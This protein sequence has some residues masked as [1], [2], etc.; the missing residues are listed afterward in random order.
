MPDP[1]FEAAIARAATLLAASRFPVVAGLQTDLAG[2]AAG[3][4]LAMKLGG[5]LDHAG[6]A[7]G[8]ADAAVLQDAGLMLVSPGEA[9]RRADTLLVVGAEPQRAWPE[10]GEFFDL[11]GGTARRVLFLSQSGIADPHGGTEL[12][13]PGGI[14]GIVAALR[15]RVN[16]RP[17]AADV[18]RAGWDL[19]AEALRATKYGVA[20]WTPG[21]LDALGVEQLVGLVKD[22]NEG[23]RWGGLS[24][25]AD[26]SAVGAGMAAGWMTGF[27]LR[28]GFGRGYPEHDPWRFDARRLVESGEVDAAVWISAFGEPAPDWLGDVVCVILADTA[29]RARPPSAVVLPVGRPGVDHDGILF[30][31]RTGTL[32]ECLASRPSAR[33]SAADVLDRITQSLPA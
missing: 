16:G 17:V 13:V 12:S 19:V 4:R 29:L 20:V 32:A 23:T 28:V 3:I 27:P 2:S 1:E 26:P 10:L 7:A 5:A 9:R 11:E 6:A 14:A 24:V 18:D 31:R 8:L 30:E 25:P 21:E 15:A 22:L 33:P